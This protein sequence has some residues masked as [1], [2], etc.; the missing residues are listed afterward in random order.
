MLPLNLRPEHYMFLLTVSK[1]QKQS[2]FRCTIHTQAS[3]GEGCVIKRSWGSGESLPG[4][5]Y[6][7]YVIYRA[8]MDC[9]HHAIHLPECF[10]PAKS[11]SRSST[12]HTRETR[13]RGRLSRELQ[14]SSPCHTAA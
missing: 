2:G 5:A 11:D 14:R 10:I 7:E 12:T 8:P 13:F 6:K 9:Y 4:F 1:E 3:L